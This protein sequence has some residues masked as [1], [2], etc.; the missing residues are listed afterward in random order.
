MKKIFLFTAFLF[1][2]I[3]NAQNTKQDTFKETNVTLKINIDQL[4]GTLTV[5]DDVK[6]CPVALIIA[7]SGPTDRNGNNPMMKNNSLKMLAE[8]LAK[9]GIASLRF[10]KRGIG[11]SK[12][13]AVTES[14]LVFENYTEDAKSWINFLKQ[15]KRF[16]QLTVIGHSE[17]SLIGMIAGAKANKFISIAGAGESADKLLKSQISSKSNKQVE[18]MTFPIIDS[19]K[20]GNKVNKVDPLLNSLFRASIQPYLISWFKY[21]PQIEIKKLTVPVLIIQGNNDLQVSVKDAENL[22]QAN[23]N[24]ELVIIDKMNHVLKIIDGDKQANMASYNN[25]NLPV[26]ETM[27]NKI[28]SFIKK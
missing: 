5:P 24:A 14:S 26:S 25:E 6:K 9:N 1:L 20:A 2:T 10:D 12:A 8:A 3:L 22:S 7:G 19:L 27:V 21:D 23:K 4:Y 11:E 16:T 13:S 28:V 17:G 15:D 18:D